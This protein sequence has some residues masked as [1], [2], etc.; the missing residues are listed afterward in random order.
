V[1]SFSLRSAAALA[2]FLVSRRDWI[3]NG[4]ISAA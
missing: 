2:L 1:V 3:G 4:L